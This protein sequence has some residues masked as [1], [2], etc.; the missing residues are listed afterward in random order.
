MANLATWLLRFPFSGEKP[1]IRYLLEPDRPAY[2]PSVSIL[3]ADRSPH[4]GVLKIGEL[5]PENGFVT[6]DGW[7]G[8]L[9][10][11]VAFKPQT[12]LHEDV[13]VQILEAFYGDPPFGG[14]DAAR[15]VVLTAQKMMSPKRPLY[16]ELPEADDAED[17]FSDYILHVNF[18][19]GCCAKEQAKSSKTAVEFGANASRALDGSALSQ[20]FRDRNAKLLSWV[21]GEALTGGKTP[22]GKVGYYVW[23]PY[24]VLKTLQDPEVPFGSIVLWTDAGV[25]FTSALRP[26]VKRYL[27]HSDVS[28]TETPMMEAGVTK[29]DAFVLL[30]ADFGSI[31]QTNQIATGIIL[32][33]KTPLSIQFMEEWLRACEDYRII[34][35][36]PSELGYPDYY[37]FRH[38]NDDQSAFS[39]LFKKFGFHPFSQAERDEVVFAA[40]NIAKF[41]AASDAYALGKSVSQDD[42]INAAN[43]A[44]S[45]GSK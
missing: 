7:F 14:K 3:R 25:I 12:T 9:L 41:L 42:Y 15:D 40:R 20:E 6:T 10:K 13:K 2:V 21:R 36:E 33:R 44:A 32:A 39:L 38:H 5:N 30:D 24:V 18:A 26:L 34:T 29:R 1:A 17:S 19:D 23:K 27:R 35:E 28:A 16:Q 37:T 11:V 43:T 31:A 8:E 22:S 4:R 45:E